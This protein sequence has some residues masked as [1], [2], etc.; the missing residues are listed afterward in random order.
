M[1][2]VLKKILAESVHEYGAKRI[3]EPK[4]EEI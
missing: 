3:V 4:R 1:N 2:M